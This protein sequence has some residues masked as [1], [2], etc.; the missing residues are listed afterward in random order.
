M[1]FSLKA[2]ALSALVASTVLAAPVVEK[3]DANSDRIAA[4]FVG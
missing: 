4:C 1:K 2:V 3:R